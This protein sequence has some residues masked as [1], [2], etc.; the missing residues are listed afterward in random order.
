M[1]TS[2]DD[3]S[4][5]NDSRTTPDGDTPP[6][7]QAAAD[8]QDDTASV[9]AGDAFLAGVAPTPSPAGGGILSAETFAATSLLLLAPTILGTRLLELFGWFGLTN[10]GSGTPGQLALIQAELLVAGGLSA[11]AVILGAT[12]LVMTGAATRAWARWGASASVLTGV[13]F[14]VLATVTYVSVPA[15]T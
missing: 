4:H 5:T 1:S 2:Q 3:T 6:T 9:P 13:L 7:D 8:P 15:G 10:A 12:S 11:L 14:T